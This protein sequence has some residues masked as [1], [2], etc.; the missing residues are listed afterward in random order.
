MTAGV[1]SPLTPLA[2]PVATAPTVLLGPQRFHPT[3]G[4]AVGALGIDGPIATITAGW[5]ERE[6]DDAELTDVLNRPT[7]NLRLHHRMYD[8]LAKDAEFAAAALTFRDRHDELLD[9]YRLRLNHA[10]A[11]V[12]SVQQRTSRQGMRPSAMDDAIETVRSIDRWY[13]SELASI[14]GEFDEQSGR[15]QSDLIGW[16]RGEIA[17]TLGES[18]AVAITGGHVG[19]LLRT[20]H[21]FADAVPPDKPVVAWSAGAMALTDRVVL[22]YD[23]APQGSGAPEMYGPG[24][25]RLPGIAVLPHARRRLNLD[26]RERTSRLARRFADHSMLLLDDGARL[27]F[28]HGVPLE[29][30]PGARILDSDGSVKEYRNG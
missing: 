17:A 16:H 26:D 2:P 22:F 4:Q 29:I 14:F 7:R 11:A 9:F 13:M 10:L 24:I 20:L 30:P 1:P 18:S 3:A 19:T 6:D 15:D 12:T 27:T 25:G 5:E 21:L 8:V 28:E 23:F